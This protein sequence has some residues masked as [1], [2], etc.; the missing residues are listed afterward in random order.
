[1]AETKS[2]H[3]KFDLI[4]AETTHEFYA[5]TEKE[6]LQWS[7]MLED[8]CHI[9]VHETIGSGEQPRPT[10]LRRMSV[11]NMSPAGTGVKKSESD[12]AVV[13]KELREVMQLPEN[14]SCAECGAK[15]PDWASVN[16]GVFICIQCSGAH[17]NLGSHISKIRSCVLDE[18][19]LSQVQL[20]K[21]IGNERANLIWEGHRDQS[22]AKPQPTKDFMDAMLSFLRTKYVEKE[23][24]FP[25][26]PRLGNNLSQLQEYIRKCFGSEEERAEVD[27]IDFLRAGP[28]KSSTA[29]ASDGSHQAGTTPTGSRNSKRNTDEDEEVD[30]L[31]FLRSSKQ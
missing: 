31:E 17:R 12:D 21:T 9:L 25:D 5:D 2:E 6:L 20:M 30:I 14:Q 11:E 24:A 27:I 3:K 1:M 19:E 13:K 15:Y 29:P 26:N 22:V 28:A 16:L 4:T 7:A 8:V 10:L 18:W 23:F